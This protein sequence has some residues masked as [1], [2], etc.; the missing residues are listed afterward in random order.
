MPNRS[1]TVIS[2]ATVIAVQSV[3]TPTAGS[4]RAKGDVP[5]HLPRRGVQQGRFLEFP[6]HVG[7]SEADDQHD[8][9]QGRHA[10]NPDSPGQPSNSAGPKPASVYQPCSPKPGLP[11][12]R[13]EIQRHEEHQ[14]QQRQPQPPAQQIGANQQPCQQR[15]Q[16]NAH[17]A[18]VA[19]A[20]KSVFRA[21]VRVRRSTE[22]NGCR[23]KYSVMG[24]R[25]SRQGT[26]GHASA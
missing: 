5:E 21:R 2:P 13:L 9:R 18:D 24:D 14:P 12:R 10:V 6:F 25:W 7:Q 8:P 3:A 4:A 23:G 17:R 22:A 15:P 11:R 20:S 1:V 16:R 19:P 26:A